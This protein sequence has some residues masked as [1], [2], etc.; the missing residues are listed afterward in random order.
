MSEEAAER[1]PVQFEF[2][3]FYEELERQ[4]SADRARFERSYSAATR[5]ALEAYELAKARASGEL[6]NSR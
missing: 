4:K 2:S 6:K 5:A 3:D 1:A